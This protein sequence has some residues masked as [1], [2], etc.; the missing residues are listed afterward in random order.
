MTGR[1]AEGPRLKA[2]IQT[3]SDGGKTKL[4][5]ALSSRGR[6]PLR[7]RKNHRRQPLRFGLAL[8]T[9]KHLRWGVREY[10]PLCVAMETED[11]VIQDE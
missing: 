3:A 5:E 2:E 1:E 7:L 6:L 11:V 8:V 10:R 9:W 4:T